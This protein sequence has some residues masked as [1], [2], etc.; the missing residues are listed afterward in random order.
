MEFN[1]KIFVL[2]AEAES[3]TESLLFGTAKHLSSKDPLQVYMNEQ[4]INVADGY[5]YLGV[6]LEPTLNMSEHLRKV[7]GKANA[8]LK[9]LSHVRD[10]LSVFAAKAVYNGIW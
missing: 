7:L 8:R 4:L 3:K 6:W 1:W 2:E 9:L 10:S 5:K